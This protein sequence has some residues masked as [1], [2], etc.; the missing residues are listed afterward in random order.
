MPHDLVRTPVHVAFRSRAT[1][2]AD[3]RRGVAMGV[4]PSTLVR[5]VGCGD[6][7]QPSDRRRATRIEP[8]AKLPRRSTNSH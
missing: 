5:A 1:L 8:S 4:A 2:T 3:T 6:A 7:W